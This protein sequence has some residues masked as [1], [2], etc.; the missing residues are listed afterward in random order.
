MDQAQTRP[1]RPEAAAAI[2]SW[3]ERR[4]AAPPAH[5]P[6]AWPARRRAL[7]QA[8]P[9]AAIG[10]LVYAWLS[11]WFGTVILT[12]TGVVLL[13]GLL[14]PRVLY[15]GIERLLATLAAGLTAGVTWIVVGVL[16]VL[17]F[18]P[19]GWLFRRGRADRMQRFFDADASSYWQPVA[20]QKPEPS[21]YERLY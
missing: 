8:V 20:Q 21:S 7:L 18:M 9:G 5:L 4:P 6:D 15:A 10:L 19:F 12:V 2:W 16:L 1:G 14:S 13:V 11:T 3:Q 17:V